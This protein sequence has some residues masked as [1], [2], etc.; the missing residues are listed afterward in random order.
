MRKVAMAAL[1]AALHKTSAFKLSDQ[2]PDFWRH[3]WK[4]GPRGVRMT[5]LCAAPIQAHHA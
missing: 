1:A 4:N 3:T 5:A 2:F